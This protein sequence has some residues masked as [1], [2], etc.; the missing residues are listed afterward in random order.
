[1]NADDRRSVRGRARDLRFVGRRGD[2][3]ER[4][5]PVARGRGGDG[6]GEVAGGCT[7]ER[8]ETELERTRERERDRSVFERERW[9]PRVI[10]DEE[11]GDAERGTKAWCSHERGPADGIVRGGLGDRKKIRVSPEG[12]R[13]ACDPV[14]Q[15]FGVE[16]REVVLRLDRSITLRADVPRVGGLEHVT[17]ATAQTAESRRSFNGDRHRS[18]SR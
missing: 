15:R 16:A 5:E 3:D 18:T 7:G 8:V 10:L 6:P 9:I 14:A 2:E 13:A 17:R 11:I 12:A 4:A 1:V